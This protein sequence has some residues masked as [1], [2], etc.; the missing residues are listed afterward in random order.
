MNL[1]VFEVG[2]YSFSYVDQ[3]HMIGLPEL[4]R[5]VIGENCFTKEKYY[6]TNIDDFDKDPNREFY[7]KDCDKLKELRIGVSSF[8]NY[9]SC[10]IED[11]AR[12]EVIEM[13]KLFY[14]SSF[15]YA[16]LEMKSCPDGMKWWIDLPKIESIT[17]G[18]GMFY[19]CPRAV[20]ESNWI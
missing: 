19:Y 12:L 18:L 5:V 8:I 16:S 10:V 20:F 15:Y 17:L 1:R 9:A 6:Y 3:V 14:W 7:L 2:D 4:E 13:G 11:N